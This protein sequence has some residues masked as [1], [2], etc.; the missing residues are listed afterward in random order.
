[1]DDVE[2]RRFNRLRE[3]C[4]RRRRRQDQPHRQVESLASVAEPLTPPV[5]S[6]VDDAAYPSELRRSSD[7]NPN[8][9]K[10]SAAVVA[11]AIRRVQSSAAAAANRSALEPVSTFL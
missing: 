1:V 5:S 4:P 6:F 8:P 10:C 7:V 2:I 9:W 3:N 11:G